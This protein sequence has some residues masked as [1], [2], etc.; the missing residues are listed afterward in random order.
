MPEICRFFGIVTA[1]YHK[2]EIGEDVNEQQ[3]ADGPSLRFGR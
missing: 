2:Y 1:M 3:P